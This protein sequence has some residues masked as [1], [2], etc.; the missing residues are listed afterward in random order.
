MH[1]RCERCSTVYELDEKILPPGGAPVQCT[2]CQH[3]FHAFPPQ[4]AGRTLP[5]FPAVQGE[6]VARPSPP[7]AGVPGPSAPGPAPRQAA[8]APARPA[9][10]PARQSPQ[11][12]GPAAPAAPAPPPPRRDRRGDTVTILARQIRSRRLW[13]WL[14]PLLLLLAAGAGYGVFWHRSRQIDPAALARRQEG[15]RLL[16]RDGGRDLEQAAQVLADASRLDPRLF[17]ARADRALALTLLAAD[18]RERVAGLESRFRT[19]DAERLRLEAEGTE[20]WRQWQAGVIDRMKAL[21][22]Q[23]E[24]IRGRAGQLSSEALGELKA[25]GRSHGD[26]PAVARALALHHA[27]DGNREQASRVVRDARAAGQADP[28]L[29][30]ADGVSD[31]VAASSEL[32]RQKAV[33]RLAPLAAAH[34]ELL[35][36]RMLLARAQVDL[37]RT[38][39]A[40]TALDGVLE[41]NAGHERARET[42]ERLL[43]PPP[44]VPLRPAVSPEAPPPG[45]PGQLP[46]RPG[47]AA[48]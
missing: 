8:P 16:A 47:G 23:I 19:L 17:Q 33:A 15:L 36:A 46:R 32:A 42:K 3:V 5:M 21:E 13:K 40:V 29:D 1:I 27:L 9:P 35:R 11:P 28:W 4:A 30:L 26:D 31:L 34:P 44:V 2:R 25:L 7:P 6:G 43:A 39:A 10:A 24:P 38:D 12:A 14:G 22:G 20:G 41:A 48:R 37:G 45:R 18:E